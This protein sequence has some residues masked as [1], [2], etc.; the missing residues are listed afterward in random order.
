MAKYELKYRQAVA[1]YIRKAACPLKKKLNQ[2]LEEIR[3]NPRSSYMLSGEFKGL[4]SYHFTH[5]GVDYRIIYEIFPQN[6]IV[7]ELIGPRENI[8]ERLRR[9]R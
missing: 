9:I 3:N 6:I 2:E 8:Y 7:I 4:F 5:R 1:K